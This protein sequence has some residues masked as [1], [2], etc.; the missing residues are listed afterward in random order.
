MV[1]FLETLELTEEQRQ[2]DD[3]RR[4]LPSFGTPWTEEETSTLSD[5][6][7][8]SLT[9]LMGLI[10]TRTATAIAGMADRIMEPPDREVQ[11]NIKDEHRR[12]RND[13]LGLPR[14][15]GTR[16][17]TDELEKAENALK[18][19]FDVPLIKHVAKDRTL[20]AILMKMYQIHK[21]KNIPASRA[22]KKHMKL[23]DLK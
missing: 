12:Y 8:M 11:R 13:E 18:L 16:W 17:T 2:E 22:L 6:L 7:Q 23:H 21:E 20:K 3:R 5:N 4:S 19:D 14:N 15:R 10:P 1:D 9:E